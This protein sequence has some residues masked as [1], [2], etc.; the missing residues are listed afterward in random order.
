MVLILTIVFYA[1]YGTNVFVA[2]TRHA[3]A[4]ELLQNQ[5]KR[6]LNIPSNQIEAVLEIKLARTICRRLHKHKIIL[7]LLTRFVVHLT[8]LP[9]AFP[10]LTV[11]LLELNLQLLTHLEVLGNLGVEFLF[12][13]YEAVKTGERLLGRFL[14]LNQRFPLYDELLR[15]LQQFVLLALPQSLSLF[16]LVDELLNTLDHTLLPVVKVV[17]VTLLYH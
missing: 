5:I 14:L 4:A 17:G 13:D 1:W 2:L 8:L 11:G 7:L 16:E 12:N 15:S 6:I 10:E 9:F 3:P